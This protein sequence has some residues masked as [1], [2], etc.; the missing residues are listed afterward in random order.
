MKD[1]T[2]YDEKS[3][4]LLDWL[5]RIEKVAVLTNIQEYKSATAISTSTLYTMLKRIG[6]DLS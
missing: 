6:N 5:L 3:M 2:V 4:N 1:I